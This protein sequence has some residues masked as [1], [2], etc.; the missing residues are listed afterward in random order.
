M[1]PN[2][3]DNI[4]P[5]ARE[6]RP[7]NTARAWA[8]LGVYVVATLTASVV[9]LAVQPHSG[10]DPAALSLV[11]FGPALGALTTWLM[12]GKTIRRLRP[13]AISSRRV[14]ARVLAMV[15]ACVVFWLL[16]TLA[17]LASGTALVGPTAVGGLPFAVFVLLQL[18]GATGEEIGWRGLMQ[19]I[20]ESR[21]ARFAAI[22]V[23]GATWALWH[24]QAFVAGPVTA[25]CFFI[26]VM[27]FA[28]VLG[29]LGD[30]GFRQRVL[31]AS[32]GHWLINIAWYLLAGENTLD[33]PQIVFA[34]VAAAL[35]AAGVPASA[36]LTAALEIAS[37]P[38]TLESPT[39]GS[40]NTSTQYATEPE[41]PLDESH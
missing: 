14:G 20:L 22:S 6:V 34:A 35:I 8:A 16:I 36:Y 39:S 19:P 15:A 2:D 17:A 4:P 1:S 23:T 26:S 40:G 18:I 27:A 25:V 12:F 29:Y 7:P 10:I 33:R 3:M 21:M 11:Q 28:I 24:V 41:Q 5:D 9:L 31:I 13:A 37:T 32:I 30:G 38:T